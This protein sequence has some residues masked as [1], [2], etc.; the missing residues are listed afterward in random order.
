LSARR[1]GLKSGLKHIL[2]HS[3]DRTD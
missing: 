2:R 1:S 3:M